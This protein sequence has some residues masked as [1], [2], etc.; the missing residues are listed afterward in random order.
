MPLQIHGNQDCRCLAQQLARVVHCIS[1]S[2]QTSKSKK[3]ANGILQ[4]PNS[5]WVPHKEPPGGYMKCNVYG[6]L[7]ILALA[8][9][10][11]AAPLAQAQA[12]ARASVPFEFGLDQK[13]MP[14]GV[15]E[16]SALNDKV[17]VVRN[18]ETK[19]ARLLIASMHVQASQAAGTPHAK[20]VFHKC[21]EEYFLA[22]IWDGQNRTGIAFPESKR[23]KEVQSASYM[24]QPEV[25][26]I[27]MK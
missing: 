27:A 18:L 12:R 1:V 22:E 17:L 14:A 24:P 5:K 10:V 26:V 23:E 9:I 11:S 2:Q 19:D 7:M 8:M 21:G 3:N 20:L 16:I 6:A 25:V 13:S 4:Q 15:Y